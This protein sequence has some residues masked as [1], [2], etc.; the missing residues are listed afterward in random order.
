MLLGD[1]SPRPPDPDPDSVL[2]NSWTPFFSLLGLYTARVT[3]A[4]A[5]QAGIKSFPCTTK[6]EL[7]MEMKVLETDKQKQ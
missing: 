3:L 2:F 5:R 7:M 4:G 6:I 1:L